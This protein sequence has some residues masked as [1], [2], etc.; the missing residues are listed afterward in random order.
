MAPPGLVEFILVLGASLSVIGLSYAVWRQ[1][2]QADPGAAAPRSVVR[3]SP[4]I[5]ASRGRVL[6]LLG[7]P[8]TPRTHQERDALR[9][10][11]LQAGWRHPA[12]QRG[13]LAARVLL[14]LTLPWPLNSLIQPE[15]GP[16]AL[17]VILL[18]VALGYYLPWGVLRAS[19]RSRQAQLLGAFPNAL[20]MLVSC[21][22][23]G[24]GLDAALKEVARA[25]ADSSPELAQELEVLISESLLGLPRAEVFHRLSERTGL[26]E[27]ASLVNVLSHA[28]RYGV[29]ISASIRTHAQL[30]R[31]RR[32]L[33]AEKRAARAVPKLTVAMILFILPTLFIVVLGPTMINIILYLQPVLE[34]VGEGQ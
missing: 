19:R 10:H 34:R 15:S 32:M 23:A 21:L 4:E 27:I 31:R 5:I 7:Q 11:L 28:E 17:M 25:M 30:V 9:R 14:A 13:Y 20:D 16:T 3:D 8:A 1:R 24:L 6:G 26:E 22:E 12:A 29:A 33:R 2:L 18:G